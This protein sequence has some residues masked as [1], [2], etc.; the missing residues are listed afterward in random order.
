[1]QRH[2]GSFSTIS[3]A[4]IFSISLAACGSKSNHSRGDAP[5]ERA[6]VQ[7]SIRENLDKVHASEWTEDCDKNFKDKQYEIASA[8]DSLEAELR[9]MTETRPPSKRFRRVNLGPITVREKISEEQPK[10]GWQEYE[11]NWLTI[12]KFFKEIQ[13]QPINEEWLDLNSV[14]RGILV[15]D[16]Q[17][18]IN[19]TNYYLDKDSGPSVLT[20]KLVLQDCH[21]QPTCTEPAYTPDLSVFIGNQPYFAQYKRA[22][23]KESEFTK[24]RE[25]LKKFVNRVTVDARDYWFSR[26]PTVKRVSAGEFVVQL[27]PGPFAEVT[28]QLQAYIEKIWRDQARSVKI[29]WRQSSLDSRVFRFIVDMLPGG[30]A[31]VAYGDKTIHLFPDVRAKSIAHEIGHV[32][33][34]TDQYYTVWH[35]ENCSYTTQYAEENLMS[36]PDTGHVLDEHWRKLEEVYPLGSM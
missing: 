19:G 7:G 12:S 9:K 15:D 4:F 16:Q 11:Y 22:L 17:R 28:T 35:P 8:L 6:G 13:N 36:E 10:S 26:N 14:V 2:A 24:K 27:D 18:V 33:G 5:D 3:L 31:Y 34:F 29:E 21:I 25:L 32:L 20:L 30:R 23:E 1:M